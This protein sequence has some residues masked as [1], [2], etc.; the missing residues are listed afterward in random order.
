MTQR[1]FPLLI[2]SVITFLFLL[3]ALLGPSLAPNDPY[4]VFN[5]AI[6]IG[7]QR[8]I[9]ASIPVPP[10][11]LPQFRL[12]TDNAGR[13]L[14]SRLLFA[15]RP[16]LILGVSIVIVRVVAGLFLGLVAGW[17][18]KRTE[19]LIDSLISISLSIPLLIFALAAL[20]FMGRRELVHFILALTLTGWANT[21]VFIKNRTQT[22]MKAPFIEGAKAVGVK[23]LRNLAAAHFATN[24]AYIAF[25]YCI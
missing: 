7:D 17:Y 19:R 16:T 24:L 5:D 3:T 22:V 14:Y 13:D 15:V 11:E 2:G 1:N 21:A 23:I 12:G 9:P 20:S 8:Y 6:V 4:E 25:P 10:L 18:Q